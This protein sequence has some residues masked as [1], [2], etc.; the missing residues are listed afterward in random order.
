MNREYIPG[1]PGLKFWS[2]AGKKLNLYKLSNFQYIEGGIEPFDD[3]LVFVSTEHAFQSR[4]YVE[5]DRIRFSINGDLGNIDGFN[6][7]F[8]EKEYEKKRDYWMKKGNIGVIAKMATNEKLG[9]KL[10]LERNPD[11][12]STD[13]LWMQILMCKYRKEEFKQLLKS[14]EDIYLLEFDRMAY[15]RFGVS[16]AFWGGNIVDN[17][18]WGKNQ[19]GKYLMK[20]RNL[21]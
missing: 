15:H 18:L 20:V 21:I 13:E 8:R 3:E 14:T 5:K 2:N 10:G 16:P 6:L 1:E 19:M 4:K 9:K 11:F 17:K 7:V 12:A